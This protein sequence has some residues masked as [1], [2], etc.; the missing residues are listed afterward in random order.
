MTKEQIEKIRR[1]AETH[2]FGGI[3]IP[4]LCDL[5]L[6]GAITRDKWYGEYLQPSAEL[7]ARAY[8]EFEK[9]KDQWLKAATKEEREKLEYRGRRYMGQIRQ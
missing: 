4:Q 1:L 7:Y 3:P 2:N 5:A 6:L 9:A 8:E